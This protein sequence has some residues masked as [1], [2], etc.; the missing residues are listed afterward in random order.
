MSLQTSNVS[1]DN[2]VQLYNID[3]IVCIYSNYKIISYTIIGEPK[4]RNWTEDGTFDYI[5][6]VRGADNK[7]L[8]ICQKRILKKIGRDVTQL[9]ELKSNNESDE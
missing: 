5:Y 8:H 6:P 3:D 1:Y 4:W 2:T 9:S 7:N